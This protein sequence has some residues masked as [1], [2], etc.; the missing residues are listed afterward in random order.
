MQESSGRRSDFARSATMVETEAWQLNGGDSIRLPNGQ[1]LKV[2]R[3]RP[4]ET[5]PVGRVYVHTDQG[6][7]LAGRYEK[8]TR[9]PDTTGQQSLPQYADPSGNSNSLPMLS[10]HPGG[11]HDPGMKAPT[12]CTACGFGTMMRQGNTYRC[13]RC[14]HVHK[15]GGGDLEY[16]DANQVVRTFSTI[17]NPMRSVVA[18][19][20]R[21]MLNN[22]ENQ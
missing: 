15:P 12:Q 17:N 1:V 11:Q 3:V 8:F 9:V 14:G 4:H 20:A 2:Q 5:D 18:S 22:E 21:Q 19:R 6:T 13:A 10:P 7:A 16:S